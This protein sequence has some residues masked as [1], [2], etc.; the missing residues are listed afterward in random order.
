MELKNGLLVYFLAIVSTT[1]SQSINDVTYFNYSLLPQT[2]FKAHSGNMSISRFEFNLSTPPI[3]IGK[4]VR[5]IN[6]LY[7]Q[8][9]QFS[10]SDDFANS[11]LFPSTLHDIRYNA[12]IFVQ[13][14]KNWE[15]LAVPRVLI[16][17]DLNQS[18]SGKDLFASSF[19]TFVHAVK[20]NPNFKVGLGVIIID[21]D[22][23][24]RPILPAAILRY[25]SRKVKVEL[26]YPRANFI[27]KQSDNFEFGLFAMVE[28]AI[29]R[30]SPLTFN[31]ETADY[32][33][34]F[35]LVVAPSVSHRMYKS[36]FAH[37]K[38][39]YAPIR[40]MELVNADFESLKNQSYD[41]QS[42]LYIRAGVSLRVP[43][44]KQ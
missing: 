19:I 26:I 15:L 38:V 25:D 11:Q 16:R 42:S 7:Y 44:D 24:G 37:L 33:R 20:G 13:L 4:R 21:N 9:S 6:S 10:Y 32:L 14:R 35:Q 1:Y 30:I 17:S 3:L 36:V 41:I 5:F 12:T 31:N 8:N 34:A 29:S 39:G 43:L 23:T 28:G 27:Y 22:F 40:S 2:D 18:L